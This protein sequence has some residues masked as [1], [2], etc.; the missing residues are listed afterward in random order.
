M[1]TFPLF[2]ATLVVPPAVTGITYRAEW[3][4]SLAPGSWTTL[5]D[6]DAAP[7][8]LFSIPLA[9]HDKIFLRRRISS[10]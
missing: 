5:P 6:T 1:K 9:G 10:P 3:S 2:S 4:P 7:L 8:R